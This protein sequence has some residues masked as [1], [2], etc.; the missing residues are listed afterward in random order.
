MYFISFKKKPYEYVIVEYSDERLQLRWVF[1]LPGLV[2]NGYTTLILFTTSR[3]YSPLYM[4]I[5]GCK[6]R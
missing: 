2:I 1:M 4:I 5:E 3:Y 6:T